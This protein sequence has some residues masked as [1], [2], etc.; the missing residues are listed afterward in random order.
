MNPL[1]VT[2]DNTRPPGDDGRLY[3]DDF[4]KMGGCQQPGCTHD[5][6]GELVLASR[7]HR[8]KPVI[9]RYFATGTVNTVCAECHRFTSAIAIAPVSPSVLCLDVQTLNRRLLHPDGTPIC[10]D[11]HCT[12][13]PEDHAIVWGNRPSKEERQRGKHRRGGV[14]AV[15]RISTGTL[16]IQC[17]E[18]PDHHVLE[19]LL[20]ARR[21]S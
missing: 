18:C 1:L 12:A 13:P 14:F 20:I 4:Q 15:Y 21:P 3:L 10:D 6:H 9:A 8:G 5:D 17:A 7:C 11:P 19:T 2:N 16:D